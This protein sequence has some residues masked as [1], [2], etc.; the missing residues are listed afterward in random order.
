[1]VLFPSDVFKR[2]CDFCDD[3]IERRQ[4]K[5]MKTIGVCRV[6]YYRIGVFAT[7]SYHYW[8]KCNFNKGFDKVYALEDRSKLYKIHISAFQKRD[9]QKTV[10]SAYNKLDMSK[11][12]IWM[13]NDSTG[14][15]SPK[16]LGGSPP[17]VIYPFILYAT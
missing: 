10:F 17:G 15:F 3:R 14:Y 11:T 12:L 9:R 2:I 1:M 5:I 7:R 8:S 6:E 4:R 13:L 16:L